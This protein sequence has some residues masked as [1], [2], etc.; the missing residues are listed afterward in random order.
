MPAVTLEEPRA[1]VA[2]SPSRFAGDG[3]WAPG[4]RRLS[5]GLVLTITLV[6]FESLAISTVMPVVADDLGGLGLYGWVFSGF[7]LGN[8]FGIVTAGQAADARGTA[9]PFAVGLGLFSAGLLVGGLAPSMSVLVAARVAQGIGAG[10]IPAVA[11]TTVSR[12]YPPALRPRVFAVFSTAWVVPGLIGPA[13]S[14]AIA[15]AFS[16]RAVFLA[17][18]PFVALAA[19]ITLPT[20]SRAAPLV[21]GVPAEVEDRRRRGLVLTLS[22]AAVLIALSGPPIVVAALLLAVGAPVAAVAFI[23]LVPVGTLRLAPGVP[24]AVLVR[25]VLT[26]AFFGTDAYVS[27]AFHEVRG[28]PTWVAGL[29]LTAGT[30]GWTAAAWVQERLVHTVGPRRLVMIGFAMLAVGIIGMHGALGPFPV[31]VAIAVW[32]LA[33]AGVGL[34]YAPLS[35]TVLG[36][37]EPGREGSAS[38]SLQLSD[39]LGVSLGTGV[40]GAFV[41]L[42][43][44]QGWAVRSALELSFAVTLAVALAGIAAARRL[45]AALP[46]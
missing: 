3:V 19:V 34:S 31:P 35:V 13:A 44:S 20:L 23:G 5:L 46:T 45:P 27:L 11:Y 12:M 22:A 29:A 40:G 24:A 18:L 28:R 38:S 39:V 2:S 43:E 30:L 21:D 16:W 33:G 4:R 32:S 26:F 14:G 41:A 25:G 37:A 17:L 15:S 8:L 6:A 9:F 36:L 1:A 7:F 42:G 10:A